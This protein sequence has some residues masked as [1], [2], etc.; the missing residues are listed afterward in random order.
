MYNAMRAMPYPVIT[1]NVGNG[2]YITNVV[3]LG[4]GERY[5]CPA[6]TF[7]FHGVVPQTRSDGRAQVGGDT[8]C[9]DDKLFL[10]PVIATGNRFLL[11]HL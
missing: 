9:G 11:P 6:S 8:L 1:H 4:C 2:V 7:M 3:F 5:A 10:S